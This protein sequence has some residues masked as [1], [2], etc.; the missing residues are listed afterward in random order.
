MPPDAFDRVGFRHILGKKVDHDPLTP[1]GQ[2]FANSSAV[3]EWSVF[4]DHMDLIEAAQL[5][6]KVIQVF[7]KQLIV[8]LISADRSEPTKRK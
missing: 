7:D 5:L 2:V 1:A 4:A 3:V 6:A 8:N